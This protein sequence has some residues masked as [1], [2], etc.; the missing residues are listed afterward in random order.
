MIF[1]LMQYQDFAFL[2]LRLVIAVIFLYHSWPKLKNPNAMAQ[3]IGWPTA[4]VFILGAV[5]LL[6]SVGIIL[7]IYTQISALLLSVIMLGA[8]GMKIMK[9]KVPFSA[10]DKTGWEF[11]LILLAA[12]ILILIVGG[13]TI[14]VFLF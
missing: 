13:G 12:N 6:S 2:I 10:Y 11:D 4:G 9:W 5:E 8:I 1:D 7:G 3:G 14:G